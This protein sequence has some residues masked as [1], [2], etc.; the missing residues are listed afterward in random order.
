[1]TGITPLIFLSLWVSLA[2]ASFIP[3]PVTEIRS[4][5]T[6]GDPLNAVPYYRTYSSS[7]VDHAYTADVPAL[8][9]GIVRSGYPV[10]GVAGLV[11]VSQELSAVQFYRLYSAAATDHFFTMSTTERDNALKAGYVLQAGEPPVYIY[12]TQICGSVPFYRLYN[13][14]G[15]DN[16]Y[17]ISESER[18]EF[19]TTQGYNDVEIA[20]YL[21][22]L[23]NTQCT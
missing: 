6:C 1:M 17:T 22:P 3:A 13:P 10:Q 23:V 21:L 5:E 15:Q 19:I 2:C 4:A 16:F 12:P 8:N 11:F 9:G 18:L 14:V 7:V 20:G